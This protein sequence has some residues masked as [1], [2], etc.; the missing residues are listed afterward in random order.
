MKNLT[1]FFYPIADL[2]IDYCSIVEP[3]E[4]SQL[5]SVVDEMKTLTRQQLSGCATNEIELIVFTVIQ[6]LSTWLSMPLKPIA[7]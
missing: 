3:L 5:M 1:E 7:P 2:F 4:A 6:L